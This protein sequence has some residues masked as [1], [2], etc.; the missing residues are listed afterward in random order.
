MAQKALWGWHPATNTWIKLQVDNLGRLVL[1]PTLLFEDTPTDGELERGPTSNWAHDHA[2]AS[3]GVHTVGTGTISSVS[4][5]N[6]DIYVDKEA[7]GAADGTS[8]ADAFIDIQDAVDSLEDIIIHAYTIHVRAGT[9]KTGTADANIVNKL[10]DTGEFPAA[11]TWAG[12]RVFN[13]D[14]G[15]WGVV[16]ARDSDDQLSIVDI[17]GAALDLFPLGTED[18]VIEPTPY[19]ETVYLN[20]NPAVNPAHAILG[21]L[22]IRA[23]HYAYGACEANVGGAGEITDTG[24]FGNIEVGDRVFVLKHDDGSAAELCTVDDI[25]NQPNRIGTT[26]ALTPT[27]NWSYAVVKTEISGSDDGTDGGT[28]RNNVFLLRGIDKVTLYGFYLTWSNDIAVR[29]RDESSE[30]WAWGIICENC[31]YGLNVQSGS[32]LGCLYSYIDGVNALTARDRSY[33]EARYVYIHGSSV[34]VSMQIQ[35]NLYL[36]YFHIDSG[37]NGI[38]TQMAD[39]AYIRTGEITAGVT[40]GLVANKNSILWKVAGITNNATTPETEAD[41]GLIV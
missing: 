7:V 4:T 37:I 35:C 10:H 2:E 15:T 23:E 11:T 21:S 34:G 33:M 32:Y 20:S 29:V 39:A 8:W 19:R 25:S 41:G 13:V 30:N 26:G 31:D 27:T 12:R 5:A 18:Y 17:A 3:T 16:S 9:K 6:K 38:D 28:A 1:D 24:A 40:N 36:R 14:D 22:I